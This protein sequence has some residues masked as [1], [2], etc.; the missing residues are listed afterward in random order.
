MYVSKYVLVVLNIYTYVEDL[1]VRYILFYTRVH[2]KLHYTAL[3][4]HCT[5]HS[6]QKEKKQMTN[7]FYCDAHYNVCIYGCISVCVMY[8]YV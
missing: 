5:Y 1:F 4:L 8:A 6:V 7:R 3:K 2:S